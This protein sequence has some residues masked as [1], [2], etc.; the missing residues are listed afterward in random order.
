MKKLVGA[1]GTTTLEDER[2]RSADS[3][4]TSDGSPPGEALRRRDK[5]KKR[6][7][8]TVPR[9]SLPETVPW[10]EVAA[11]CFQDERLLKI[12]GAGGSFP[13]RHGA[14]SSA[15]ARRKALMVARLAF[16]RGSARRGAAHLR[17]GYPAVV[18]HQI[19]QIPVVQAQVRA[20]DGRVAIRV[21]NRTAA[22]PAH[23]AGKRSCFLL[24]DDRRLCPLSFRPDGEV[25]LF[26]LE[27]CRTPFYTVHSSDVGCRICVLVVS[28]ALVVFLPS[29]AW[30]HREW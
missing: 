13:A 18:A 15:E 10:E 23:A 6:R 21:A 16:D 19:L 29:L 2:L 7:D 26:Q 11:I 28:A 14:R 17:F 9:E 1:R 30:V 24:A 12:V 8:K 27:S 3:A 25:E 5:K 20:G 4:S 22:A